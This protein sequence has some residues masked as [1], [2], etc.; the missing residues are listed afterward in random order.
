MPLRFSYRRKRLAGARI[1]A[2]KE[3]LGNEGIVVK[4]RVMEWGGKVVVLWLVGKDSYR[5]GVPG[6]R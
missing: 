4:I 5:A 3:E 1:K 2:L 6:Q